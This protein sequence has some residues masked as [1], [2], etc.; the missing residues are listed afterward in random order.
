MKQKYL[1]TIRIAVA[2]VMFGLF[3]A[4]G[5]GV[6]Q[7]NAVLVPFGVEGEI[8]YTSGTTAKATVNSKTGVVTGGAE[9]SSVITA[10]CGAYSA[11]CTV[12]VSAAS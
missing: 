8:T 4:V 9:G 3:F 11:T 7:L 2:V 6:R 12:T 10:R 1:K 5:I